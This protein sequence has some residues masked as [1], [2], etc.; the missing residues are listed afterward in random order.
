M[1]YAIN[2][3]VEKK[4]L[5]KWQMRFLKF[6]RRWKLSAQISL[7]YALILLA[8]LIF[9]GVIMT[10]GVYYLFHHQAARAINIS[11]EHTTQEAAELQTIDETFLQ[12]GAVM[13]SVILRVTDESGKVVVDN[14]PHFPTNEQMLARVRTD[15]PFWSS[16]EF[17]LIETPH[18]FFYYK[19][20]PLTVGGKVF[21]FHFL[22]TITFEKQFI[23]YLLLTLF[24]IDL[25]G[26]G[27]AVMAGHI[28]GRRILKPLRQVTKTA[29]EISAGN[30]DRRL[31]IEE[32]GDEVNALSMSFNKMLDRLEEN[33]RQQQRFIADAS[34]E[35][36]TPITIIRGYADMLEAYGAEDPELVA[37]ASAAIKNSAQNM[38]YIVESLLFLA[39]AD[40]GIQPIT[41]APVEINDVL[42]AAVDSFKNPRI[43]F[44]GAENFETLGDAEF[45]KKMFAAFID[46]AVS[47]SDEEVVV[48]LENFGGTASVKIIDKGIGIAPENLGRIF[49][50]FFRED[51]SRTKDDDE[52]IS[53]GLGLSIAKWIAD[54]HGI[55]I[56]VTS[57]IGKG[58]TFELTFQR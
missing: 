40:Q 4:S 36:R 8:A 51:K 1:S 2:A 20:L 34:H 42:R 26:L 11:I 56:S 54:K 23:R 3:Y 5:G 9:T 52:S 16:S 17:K 22:K 47:Y 28:L 50:R 44:S 25:I 58:S 49:D 37:E 12:S 6:S 55:K 43:N 33:F 45:L 41:K 31:T 21:H 53:A 38:Q 39:R 15:P 18:S 10:A 29:Q 57:E 35:L 46:N 32:A 27:L 48:T 24:V 13:P 30:L 19:N 14:S 7:T